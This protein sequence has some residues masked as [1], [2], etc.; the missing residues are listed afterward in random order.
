MKQKFLLLFAIISFFSTVL[1]GNSLDYFASFLHLQAPKEAFHLASNVKPV[2]VALIDTGID[3]KHFFLQNNIWKNFDELHGESGKD[4][5]KNGYV[6]DIYGYDFSANTPNVQDNVGHGTHMMGIIGGKAYIPHFSSNK[7]IPV[8]VMALKVTNERILVNSE[9]V[10]NL[11]KAILYAIQKEADVISIHV[12]MKK[13]SQ[14]IEEVLSQA[15]EQGIFIVAAVGNQSENIARFPA[16]L[17]EVISVGAENIN[18]NKASFSNYGEGVD[19]YAPGE[20]ILST[21]LNGF[22]S[23]QS[24][25]SQSAALVT[26]ILSTL[27]VYEEVS[28]TSTQEEVIQKI[29]E[30]LAK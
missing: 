4:D 27:L 20:H 26:H 14:E 13:F 25:S 15:K 12:G 5:D 7:N 2:R 8:E 16:I 23:Y 29:K 24:G 17:P 21:E 11:R 22:L 3:K 18:Q 1:C 28:K 9:I 6:D 19:I 10:N 30:K